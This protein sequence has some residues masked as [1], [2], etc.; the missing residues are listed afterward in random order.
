MATQ[1]KSNVIQAAYDAG[2]PT[3]D[4][5]YAMIDRAVL[6]AL[7]VVDDLSIHARQ[8]RAVRAPARIQAGE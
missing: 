1:L 4:D 3:T 8:T 7:T 2:R 5:D 6:A